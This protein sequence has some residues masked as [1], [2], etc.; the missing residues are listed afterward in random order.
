MELDYAFLSQEAKTGLRAQG[1]GREGWGGYQKL[2]FL[3]Q[4]GP[5]R[6]GG[7]SL[8]LSPLLLS[9]SW[10][11]ADTADGGLSQGPGVGPHLARG[12]RG[13]MAFG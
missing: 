13:H 7:Y 4:G 5:V 11:D 10:R 6:P 2:L 8:Y 12:C 1:S 9:Q 3:F